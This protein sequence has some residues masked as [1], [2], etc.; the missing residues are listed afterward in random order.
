MLTG[1]KRSA[2]VCKEFDLK[3]PVVA[4]VGGRTSNGLFSS[5]ILHGPRACQAYIAELER[6]VW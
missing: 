4:V 5:L 6:M 1:A 2:Q 3:D